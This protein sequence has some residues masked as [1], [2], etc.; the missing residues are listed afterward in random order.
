MM[1]RA[2][3]QGEMMN[4]FE[5]DTVKSYKNGRYQIDCRL[6]LWGVDAYTSAQAEYE[7]MHYYAQYKKD[8][9]YDGT[10]PLKFLTKV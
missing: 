4:S 2:N 6:G 5:K 3:D 7:A 9:E 10:F 1:M 8:G